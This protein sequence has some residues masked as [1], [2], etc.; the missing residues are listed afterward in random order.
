MTH[1][2]NAERPPETDGIRHSGMY[3]DSCFAH[4]ARFNPSELNIFTK[5]GF[6]FRPFD[7]RFFLSFSSSSGLFLFSLNSFVIELTHEDVRLH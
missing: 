6:L 3:A 7:D 2:L 4:A 1:V 5:S